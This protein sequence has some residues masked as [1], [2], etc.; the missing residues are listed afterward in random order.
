MLAR[1]TPGLLQAQ[2][3]RQGALDNKDWV[4]QYVSV[5]CG[6]RDPICVNFQFSLF[7][8]L[9]TTLCEDVYA[10]AGRSRWN[11]YALRG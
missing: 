6:N 11:A 2:G 10:G 9:I 5:M 4:C 3:C 8:K 1:G 7:P